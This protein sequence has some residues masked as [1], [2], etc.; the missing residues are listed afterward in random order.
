MNHWHHFF[1]SAP[2]RNILAAKKAEIIFLFRPKEKFIRIGIAEQ[3]RKYEERD[4]I[5]T[6]FGPISQAR[7]GCNEIRY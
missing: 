4:D 5:K 2:P 6:L 1:Q 3:K 7:R